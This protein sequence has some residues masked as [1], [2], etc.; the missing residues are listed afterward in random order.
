M[1]GINIIQFGDTLR[2]NRS[3]QCFCLNVREMEEYGSINRSL[4]FNSSFWFPFCYLKGWDIIFNQFL[5][6]QANKM[7]Q[8][9][10]ES[11]FPF[12]QNSC[13]QHS[14]Y[15]QKT[16]K[17]EAQVL[18]L[19]FEITQRLQREIH[20]FHFRICS[21]YISCGGLTVT[22]VWPHQRISSGKLWYWVTPLH[23]AFG[24]STWSS[25]LN[26]LVDDNGLLHHR[27]KR[28]MGTHFKQI[29]C[30]TS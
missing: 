2:K 19:K 5:F 27:P 13:A 20:K 29:S 23:W 7:F 30:M 18:Q 25:Y 28:V 6:W 8:Q 26:D 3:I 11:I 24:L 1:Y 21:T 9:R 16:W 10:N 17:M 4:D 15:L 22:Q 12:F 14:M